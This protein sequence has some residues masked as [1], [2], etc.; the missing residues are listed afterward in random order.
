MKKTEAEAEAERRVHLREMLEEG[1]RCICHISAPC[2]LHEGMTMEE[3]EAYAK[4]GAPAVLALLD[5]AD[6][7]EAEA[8]VEVDDLR[9]RAEAAEAQRD[10]AQAEA[11][12][13][14]A[15]AESLV[16]QMTAWGEAQ[17]ELRRKQARL[18]AL[19]RSPPKLP[20]LPEP[21]P[22]RP[23]AAPPPAKGFSLC[24]LC[25]VVAV[26]VTLTTV[27]LLVFGR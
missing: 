1:V 14:K 4:G 3:D 9:A 10:L 21:E 23:A 6:V 22:I 19:L 15:H 25:L 8:E 11:E 18:D 13:W 5:A 26:A 24:P 17:A 2:S 7:A 16:R 12:R 27:V 20:P